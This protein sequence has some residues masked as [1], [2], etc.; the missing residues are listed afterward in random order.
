M[1]NYTSRLATLGEGST[2]P[3]FPVILWAGTIYT[4]KY[5]TTW[6]ATGEGIIGLGPIIVAPNTNNT[7]LQIT[8]N[9]N[10]CDY[11]KILSMH[12]TLQRDSYGDAWKTDAGGGGYEGPFSVPQLKCENEYIYYKQWMKSSG[13]NQ[14]WDDD[15]KL[16]DSNRLLYIS[17]TIVGY[18]R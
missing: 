3:Y 16:G 6:H 12:A 9:K 17:L 11:Y 18:A 7:V 1:T 13:S 4:D 15:A 8:I 5:S 14:S 10:L 2:Y